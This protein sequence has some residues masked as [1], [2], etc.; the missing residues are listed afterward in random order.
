MKTP[1]ISTYH[2]GQMSIGL[3]FCPLHVPKYE[4]QEVELIDE[5]SMAR[6]FWVN[7]CRMMIIMYSTDI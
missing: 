2:M 3:K 5:E 4:I 7:Y 6:P 1:H